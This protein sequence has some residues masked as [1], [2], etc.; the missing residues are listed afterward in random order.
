MQ[1][2]QLRFQLGRAPQ[3]ERRRSSRPAP[4]PQAPLKPLP[5]LSF[6]QRDCC[7]YLLPSSPATAAVASALQQTS[8]GLLPAFELLLTYQTFHQTYAAMSPHPCS[9]FGVNEAFLL[10]MNDQISANQ[11]VRWAFKRLIQRWRVKKLRTANTADVSTMEPPKQPITIIDWPNRSRYVFEASTLFR[12]LKERLYANS[13]L[14]PT[15]LQPRNPFTNLPLS[16]GQLHFAIQDLGQRGFQDAALLLLRACDYERARFAHVGDRM[17]RAAAVRR[18]ARG[19]PGAEEFQTLLLEFI[20][21]QYEL[22]GVNWVGSHLWQWMLDYQFNHERI[23]AWRT[24]W[25]QYQLAHVSE[26]D[27]TRTQELQRIQQ[28]CAELVAE[29]IGVLVYIYRRR[30]IK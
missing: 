27:V 25:A 15:P 17:L 22:E 20:E 12:D 30:S 26:P 11:T 19:D 1:P 14:F 13:Y 9:P 21:D 28:R 3:R 7:W 29:P 10:Q 16:L 4:A 24:L 5:P 2:V 18:M 8:Y 6:S 23:Q